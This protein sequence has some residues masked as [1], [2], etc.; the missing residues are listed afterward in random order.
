MSASGVVAGEALA[1][2]HVV[3]SAVKVRMISSLQWG[4]LAGVPI[5]ARTGSAW[6]HAP[7]IQRA[8]RHT[9]AIACKHPSSAMH[10]QVLSD[11]TDLLEQQAMQA[12]GLPQ[13][14][15]TSCCACYQAACCIA[16]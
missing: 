11:S 8:K 6:S 4:T 10:Q 12:Q 3:A 1:Y 15:D 13:P 2:K 9:P 14:H 7:L 16:A 5:T